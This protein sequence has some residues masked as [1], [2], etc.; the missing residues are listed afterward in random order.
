MTAVG[1]L[2]F[3]EVKVQLAADVSQVCFVVYHMQL[4][5]PLQL[6]PNVQ[7]QVMISIV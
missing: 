2:I 5:V 6:A 1:K 3:D 7:V 4:P